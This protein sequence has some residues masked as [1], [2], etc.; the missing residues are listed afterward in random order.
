MKISKLLICMGLLFLAPSVDAMFQIQDDVDQLRI[1]GTFVHK[2]EVY[3]MRNVEPTDLGNFRSIFG[4]ATAMEK[5]MNG[6]PRSEEEIVKR[7]GRYLTCWQNKDPW[8]SYLIFKGE[9]FVGHVLLEEGDRENPSEA[10][11][12]Y[13]FKPE[14][15]NQGIGQ[16]SVQILMEE[17]V[18][19]LL[20][21]TY[22]LKGYPIIQ[23]FVTA[24]PDNLA[25]C[26]VVEKNGFTLEYI[27]EKF[28]ANRH[29]YI[30]K[31]GQ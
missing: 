25:S 6:I 2:D 13:V 4:N 30:K 15:W 21:P 28:E 10:E 24:R 1:R 22:P 17:V 29:F 20:V 19:P 16:K 3:T 8:S 23:I 12:S 27:Q 7:H 14:F 31:V 18:T 11:L 9:A 5:Y 26:K